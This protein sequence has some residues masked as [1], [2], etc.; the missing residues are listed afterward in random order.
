MRGRAVTAWFQAPWKVVAGAMSPDLLPEAAPLV[1]AR[2]RYYDLGFEAV[3]GASGHCVSPRSGR[4]QEGVV[5]FTARGAGLDGE[6]SV[7][8]WTDSETYMLWGREVFGWPVRLAELDLSG[9]LWTSSTLDG[10]VGECR[11]AD[12]WGTA[13]LRDVRVTGPAPTGTPSGRWL[14]PRRVIHG[15]GRQGE[16]REL[17]VVRPVVNK[18]GV[19]YAATGKVSF[20]FAAPHPLHLLNEMDAEV[21]VAD[22]FELLIGA[23]TDVVS[24]SRLQAAEPEGRFSQA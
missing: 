11:L 1:R 16:T 9:P 14:T 3:G 21:E 8:L 5:A 18:P 10:A 4:F 22:G 23:D 2:L 13:A 15:A 24:P 6:V 17:L 7:F 20:S 12:Q 19:R